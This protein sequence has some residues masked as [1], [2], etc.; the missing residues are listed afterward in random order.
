MKHSIWAIA[1]VTILLAGPAW[2]ADSVDTYLAATRAKIYQELRGEAANA[3]VASLYSRALSGEDPQALTEQ[4]LMTAATRRDT[5][6]QGEACRLFVSAAE[7]GFAPAQFLAG[8]CYAAGTLTDDQAAQMQRWYAAAAA[9]GAASAQCALGRQ[10]MD[11]TLIVR[12]T[13]RGYALCEEAAQAGSSSAA[14]TVAK[15]QISGWSGAPDYAKAASYL[16]TATR[17]GNAEAAY[18]LASLHRDGRRGLESTEQALVLADFAAKRSHVPAFI[19]A[20]QFRMDALS[21]GRVG[22]TAVRGDFGWRLFY[23]ATLAERHDPDRAVKREARRILGVLKQAAP[24][25]VYSRWTADAGR[26]RPSQM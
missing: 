9:Q 4:G 24:D 15:A 3:Y 6:G 21:T 8:D 12:D 16:K 1:A 23:W 22:G 11:G 26:T 14:V 2:A 18:L 17:D 7:L 10:L 20:A 19:L 25:D 13:P 5:E